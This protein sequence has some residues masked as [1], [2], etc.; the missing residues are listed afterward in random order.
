MNDK[1]RI[2]G[3]I[4]YTLFDEQGKIKQSGESTNLVTNQGDDYYVDQLSDS[5]GSA[6]QAFFLGTGTTAVAK[7]DT[8]VEGYYA[9]NG[10]T[11]AG[12]GGVAITTHPTAGSENTLRYTGTF[13]AGYGTENGIT[14][15]GIA[16]MIAAAD[17]N[18]TPNATTSF[19]IAHG[20][21]TPTV[22]KGAS[23]VLVVTW[24]HTFLGA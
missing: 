24:D 13:A 23:D 5:G 20:T 11:G 21:I 3:I 7:G 1:S 17:G 4:R 16:N 14:K 9:G 8:W 19:F 18:G 2:K 6:A 22:N 15:I 10:S 12:E